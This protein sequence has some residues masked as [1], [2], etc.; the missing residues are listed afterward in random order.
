[1]QIKDIPVHVEVTWVLLRQAPPLSEH[2]S[3]ETQTSL[4][5]TLTAAGSLP[6]VTNEITSSVQVVYSLGGLLNLQHLTHRG[7]WR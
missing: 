4:L 7:K 5:F 6:S 1:M 3:F 2:E